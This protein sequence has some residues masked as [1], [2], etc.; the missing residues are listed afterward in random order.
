MAVRCSGAEVEAAEFGKGEDPPLLPLLCSLGSGLEVGV[1]LGVPV[2]LG[3]V[4]E[5]GG[6]PSGVC[7]ALDVELG[8]SSVMFLRAGGSEG[9]SDEVTP[10]FL[11]I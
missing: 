7:W 1:A 8:F 3:G 6:T 10:K 2:S 11:L 4:M 5:G 9:S